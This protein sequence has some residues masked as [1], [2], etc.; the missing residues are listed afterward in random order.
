MCWF[1]QY[2]V[3]EGHWRAIQKES[4]IF[5]SHLHCVTP[6][7]TWAWQTLRASQTQQQRKCN[8]LLKCWTCWSW[9]LSFFLVRVNTSSSSEARV[10]WLILGKYCS[11]VS[12]SWAAQVRRF[13]VPQENK[14]NSTNVVQFPGSLAWSLTVSSAQPHLPLPKIPQNSRSMSNHRALAWKLSAK[15][16]MRKIYCWFQALANV[17]LAKLAFEPCSAPPNCFYQL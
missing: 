3:T 6:S 8:E 14:G 7:A 13:S 2:D 17:L 5:H 10:I 11:L 15:F 9:L 12:L 16:K 4:L 1:G